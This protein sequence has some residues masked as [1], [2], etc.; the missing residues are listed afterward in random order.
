[1]MSSQKKEKKNFEYVVKNV[2][3]FIGMEGHGFNASLYRNGKKV[4]FVIDSAQGGCFDFQWT[5]W[6][7]PKVDINIISYKGE[8][9]TFQGTP[10]E[11]ILTELVET[12]PKAKSEVFP[13]G[14]KET[15]DGF[16][17]ILIDQFE[18]K[19]W[20]KRN[21]KKCFV[22]QVGNKIGSEEYLM[23]KKHPN[24]TKERVIKLIEKKYPNQK[25][26]LLGE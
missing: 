25:Y 22:F 24:L 7:E 6:E 11:K 26:K 1:M 16:V 5:D 23:F 19:K 17:A 9:H 21:L 14:V 15:V 10:E 4:A 18:R 2:K 20:L 3:T 13:D 12:L 8:P